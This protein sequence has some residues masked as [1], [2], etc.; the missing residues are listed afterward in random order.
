MCDK[1]VLAATRSAWIHAACAPIAVA[2][3]LTQRYH[4]TFSTTTSSF[5]FPSLAGAA[6]A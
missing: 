5:P 4:Q 1:R 3:G 6:R 2:A